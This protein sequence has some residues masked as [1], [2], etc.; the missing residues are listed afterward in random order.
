[1]FLVKLVSEAAKH[2]YNE[3]DRHGSILVGQKSRT[4]RKE[5]ETKDAL[6]ASQLFD[7]F[8]QAQLIFLIT[9]IIIEKEFI[10]LSV[11]FDYNFVI[12]ICEIRVNCIP[13]R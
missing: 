11:K 7:L 1:M 8:S 6:K 2:F 13:D 4:K 3:Q 5:V 9:L 10:I 12:F